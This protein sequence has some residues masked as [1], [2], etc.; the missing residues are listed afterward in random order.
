MVSLPLKYMHSPIEVISLTDIE[1][2]AQLLAAFTE[3]LGKEGA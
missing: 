2:T 1:W 3:G